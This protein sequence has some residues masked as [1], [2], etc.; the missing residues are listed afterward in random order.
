M[1]SPLARCSESQYGFAN[2]QKAV[3]NLVFSMETSGRT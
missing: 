2:A 3:R 1:P